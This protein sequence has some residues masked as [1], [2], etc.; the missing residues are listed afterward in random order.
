MICEISPHSSRREARGR[1]KGGR[2]GRRSRASAP[3]PWM[4]NSP[5][6]GGREGEREGGRK[7]GRNG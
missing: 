7:G 6:E 5:R 4:K 1:R 3:W 2:A